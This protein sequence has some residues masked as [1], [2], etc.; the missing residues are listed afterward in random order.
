[1]LILSIKQFIL[2][3]TSPRVERLVE[4]RNVLKPPLYL[5]I[6]LDL[7]LLYSISL[8]WRS[9]D[10]NLCYGLLLLVFWIKFGMSLVWT[11]VQ[12]TRLDVWTGLSP[13]Q[14]TQSSCKYNTSRIIFE[15]ITSDSRTI[16]KSSSFTGNI[17]K[18]VP[19]NLGLEIIP[20][21]SLKIG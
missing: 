20:Y 4:F 15:R 13:F 10:Y 18:T 5:K 16:I 7:S 17:L 21:Q 9:F 2:F 19:V 12:K 3:V 8:L 11:T 6:N 14:S 1:M